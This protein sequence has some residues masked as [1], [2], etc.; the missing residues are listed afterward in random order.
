VRICAATQIRAKTKSRQVSYRGAGTARNRRNVT[1]AGFDI[2][3]VIY[4]VALRPTSTIMKLPGFGFGR[5]EADPGATS[6]NSAVGR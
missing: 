1:V 6:S 5:L 4:G 2:H 3:G